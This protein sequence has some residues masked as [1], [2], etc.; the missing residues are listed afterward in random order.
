MELNEL[1]QLYGKYRISFERKGDALV[2]RVP[3]NLHKPDGPAVYVLYDTH[4]GTT[5]V[6]LV[7][8]PR[9]EVDKTVGVHPLQAALEY[10]ADGNL[11]GIDLS[12]GGVQVG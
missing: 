11:L 3:M 12:G 10:D 9:F 5:Y 8:E 2:A 4:E 6:R 1:E 7:D